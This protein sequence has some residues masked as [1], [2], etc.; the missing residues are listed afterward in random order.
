[1]DVYWLMVGGQDPVAYLKKYPDRFKVLHIKDEYVIGESGKLDFE[2]IFKQFYRNGYEDWFVEMEGKM[3]P[4]Q[5][6]QN[7]ARME[8]M[9]QQQSQGGQRQAS[10]GGAQGMARP[11][12]QAGAP[13]Q[14]RS[15]GQGAP[16]QGPGQRDP[17]AVAEQL[18]TSLDGIKQS[19]DYLL[20]SA[21]VK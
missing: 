17:K 8:Q 20:K 4:E 11:A 19:A 16:A 5:R 10:Q 15:A 9:K 21:F 13:S 2:A 18:K 6:E 3:P 7:L 12:A 14:G 1:M